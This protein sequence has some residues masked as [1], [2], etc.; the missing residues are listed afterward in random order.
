MRCDHC[1]R[2]QVPEPRSARFALVLQ[3]PGRAEFLPAAV[4]NA[5]QE[6]GP[7]SDTQ[8]HPPSSRRSDRGAARSGESR[9]TARARRHVDELDPTWSAE[10]V[11][12]A[13]VLLDEPVSAS[14]CADL[15]LAAS[16]ILHDERQPRNRRPGLAGFL[17]ELFGG[18]SPEE[19]LATAI[20]E[21]LP[22]DGSKSAI[23]AARALQALGIAACREAGRPPE[24]CPCFADPATFEVADVLALI[25]RCAAGDWT[26]LV[27]PFE[28][29]APG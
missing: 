26:D 10:V 3:T 8:R 29:L 13:A 5:A 15:A 16:R 6:G 17:L 11:A 24:R 2:H 21:S 22:L 9:L 23:A 4:A 14:H 18:P 1:R 12:H 20:A 7:T 25:I 19:M 28:P 27:I